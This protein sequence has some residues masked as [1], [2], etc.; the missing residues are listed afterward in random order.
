MASAMGNSNYREE[1]WGNFVR[2]QG[3]E[4]LQILIQQLFSMHAFRLLGD[5]PFWK[6][7]SSYNLEELSPVLLVAAQQIHLIAVEGLGTT[8]PVSLGAILTAAHICFFN[9][10]TLDM[11]EEM[12]SD[13]IGVLWMDLQAPALERR[14]SATIALTHLLDH[15]Q[16]ANGQLMPLLVSV[17]RKREIISALLTPLH[18]EVLKHCN[19]LLEWANKQRLIPS[20]LVPTLWSAA[21]ELHESTRNSV[22][23][24]LVMLSNSLSSELVLA[25]TSALERTSI[26]LFD[27]PFLSFLKLFITKLATNPSSSP[28]IQ[29]A[30][31][32]LSSLPHSQAAS[33]ILA[34][35]MVQ[36][37][38]IEMAA[39]SFQTHF[40]AA[41][42]T[43]SSVQ[44][45]AVFVQG[46]R[47]QQVGLEN[48][49][50]SPGKFVD[51]CIKGLERTVERRN[52]ELRV[53]AW[54]NCID[55]A[56]KLHPEAS[57]NPYLTPT[58]FH[59]LWDV[60]LKQESGY[61]E[62]FFTFL[63]S[64]S[65]SWLNMATV[66]PL[67]FSIEDLNS[68]TISEPWLTFLSPAGYEGLFRFIQHTCMD[69]EVNYDLYSYKTSET[70]GLLLLILCPIAVDNAEVRM[71]STTHLMNL[72]MT[73][74]FTNICMEVI[75]TALT[76]AQTGRMSQALTLVSVLLATETKYTKSLWHDEDLDQAASKIMAEN[77]AWLEKLGVDYIDEI[78]RQ[79]SLH[80]HKAKV[81][82]LCIRI[83]G[84]SAT[85]M[86]KIITQSYVQFDLRS[87]LQDDHF[88]LAFAEIV[89]VYKE[90]T[91]L[92][93][94]QILEQ[95]LSCAGNPAAFD[96]YHQSPSLTMKLIWLQTRKADCNRAKV[97]E[98]FNYLE[99]P[100]EEIVKFHD[101]RYVLYVD[102][103]CA[104][105]AKL[106]WERNEALDNV[107]LVLSLLTATS[108]YY[109]LSTAI[110]AL[111]T[112]VFRSAE[113]LLTRISPSILT[114]YSNHIRDLAHFSLC[115]CP[116]SHLRQAACSLLLSLV[117]LSQ[118]VS[119][120]L[121]T[122]HGQCCSDMLAAGNPATEFF[123]LLAGV[124]SIWDMGK[125]QW[126]EGIGEK[127]REEQYLWSCS[128]ECRSRIMQVLAAVSASLSA[129]LQTDLLTAIS[130]LLF[131]YQPRYISENKPGPAT[132]Q[133]GLRLLLA[134]LSYSHCQLPFVQALRPL[135]FEPHWRS[136]SQKSWKLTPKTILEAGYTGISN[137]GATCYMASI[138]Q[139]LRTIPTFSQQL[140]ALPSAPNTCTALIE[141]F[142]RLLYKGNKRPVSPAALVS[143]LA[144]RISLLEQMDIEEF[145]NFLLHQIESELRATQCNSLVEDHFRGRLL[146]TLV[147]DGCKEQRPN[148][149]DFLTLTLGIKGKKELVESLTAMV[150][151][152]LMAGDN[153][154]DC[155]YCG[156]AQRSYSR[157]QIQV[158]PKIL[159]CS[160]R[161]FEYDLVK[162]IRRK[163]NDRFS[164]PHTVDF[165]PFCTQQDLP[166]D[167][168]QYQLRGVAVHIGMAEAG[169]YYSIVKDGDKWLKCDDE[170]VTNYAISDLPKEAF[171]G[172]NERAVMGFNPCAYLLVYERDSFYTSNSSAIMPIPPPELLISQYKQQIDQKRRTRWQLRALLDS[173]F[174]D[175]I[176]TLIDF[177]SPIL[178]KFAI[179]YFLTVYVRS[180]MSAA[181][182]ELVE[183]LRKRLET[184]AECSE[185]LL[186]V[187]SKAEVLDEFLISCPSLPA[188]KSVTLLIDSAEKSASEAVISL[189]IPRFAARLSTLSF[190]R[191]LKS[192]ACFYEA[193]WKL[194]SR[195]K[196]PALDCCLP[197]LLISVL[198]DISM[199]DYVFTTQAPRLEDE[200]YL[201]QPM[202][203]YMREIAT[204]AGSEENIGYILAVL[205]RLISSDLS[206]W[207][208][209][210]MGN[211]AF[212]SNLQLKTHFE[213]LHLGVFLSGCY[214]VQAE[215]V[216]Q[217]LS[218]YLE[219]V[220]E[221]VLSAAFDILQAFLET[222]NAQ[223]LEFLLSV[224]P[225]IPVPAASLVPHLYRLYRNFSSSEAWKSPDFI[226]F[227]RKIDQSSDYL[228]VLTG[229]QTSRLPPI[230]QRPQS[231]YDHISTSNTV[232]FT[233]PN[234]LIVLK[235]NEYVWV[236]REEDAS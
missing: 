142:T 181:S 163:L 154:I 212:W 173:R 211:I 198:F 115:L 112:S 18:C 64:C 150:Q 222:S 127:C 38:F 67:I 21:V 223:P 169:H 82:Y 227:L 91:G 3:P 224:L 84:G 174:Q 107:D 204:V 228:K 180:A 37:M 153:A 216:Y 206:P 75:L 236:G 135:L 96:S 22:S 208:E 151:G 27:P 93:A 46:L 55:N 52:E 185:W 192:L 117:P 202:P 194:T 42:Q 134:L 81:P 92:Q 229:E 155:P 99:P 213:C 183:K 1:L 122:H 221:S 220:S 16:C 167:Y 140:I 34:D 35:L 57:S 9:S 69:H 29:Q 85:E 126:M 217:L 49:V 219:Y 66:K 51:V 147:C 203:E 111:T 24:I 179:T 161:R 53:A 32:Q 110:N 199:C 190:P 205:N 23:Q 102:Q 100:S 94:W 68:L 182:P 124:V 149:Q 83:V 209:A 187:I 76:F 144:H 132:F 48:F 178:L 231:L 44:F 47:K 171:G 129:T 139:Q 160:L 164:F 14:V 65:S 234:A 103:L 130:S 104:L 165:R 61:Q 105:M 186:E 196:Q 89:E 40:Q 215:G 158:L 87:F 168:Y 90:E 95:A 114:L 7:Y 41:E 121:L 79:I 74:K 36:P 63:G 19:A 15:Y 80:A 108:Q 156:A 207:I 210:A 77:P 157:Q 218:G 131:Y 73:L 17:F 6:L 97:L 233:L 59:K 162:G 137:L 133:A 113:A 13:W 143:T 12:L 195:C 109:S 170:I 177:D 197:E 189:A 78:K 20:S 136:R 235:S 188:R 70:P 152:E 54:L 31:T 116:V 138:I 30:F 226:Q 191:K 125:V 39:T 33:E 72:L 128:D 10:E 166:K 11:A 106:Y 98:L 200:E 214:S 4:L 86:P 28:F 62:Q 176:S 148:S 118:S 119:A 25:F 56:G 193:M 225:T 175:F 58:Q 26:E 120:L 230:P 201:G 45:L 88:V 184:N 50:S 172:G 2:N 43:L 159:V 5:L 232:K 101:F 71:L 123:E 146:T 60:M 145:F 141:L 8:E